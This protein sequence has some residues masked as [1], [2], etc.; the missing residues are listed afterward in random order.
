M[1]GTLLLV[2]RT[3]RVV[4]EQERVWH[5]SQTLVER[6]GLYRARG[7]DGTSAAPADR[8]MRDTQHRH[9]YKVWGSGLHIAAQCGG[10][11]GGAVEG[12]ASVRALL[13]GGAEPH[14]LHG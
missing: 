13:L 8:C 2:L 1:R 9:T 5:T 14:G 3:A 7:W 6:Q 12:L 10:V 4:E 11:R